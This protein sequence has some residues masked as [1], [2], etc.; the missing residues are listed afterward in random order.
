MFDSPKRGVRGS[1]PPG[2]GDLRA[3]IVSRNAKTVPAL[4]IL[5]R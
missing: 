2:D 3:G 1:N 5:R 4:F